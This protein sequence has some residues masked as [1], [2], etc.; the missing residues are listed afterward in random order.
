MKIIKT[1]LNT[2]KNVGLFNT[3]REKEQLAYSVSADTNVYEDRGSIIL[4][5]LTTTD[6]KNIGEFTYDNLQKSINGF[7]RQV[8]Q[9]LNS[10]YTDE[11]LE[12]AKKILKASMLDSE[13]TLKK[14][15]L[16]RNNA[17]NERPLDYLNETYNLI[18]SITRE[19]IDEY[20]KIMFKDKPVYS[21][22][23]SQDTLNYN[24]DYLNS[25]K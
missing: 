7:N 15:S 18:D 2:S 25:L 9:L 4:N 10:E 22:V 1:L 24:K 3:L 14:L 16:L 12:S 19:D 6:N 21:I 5:I 8:E 20:S 23:A 11:D 13:G 17:I